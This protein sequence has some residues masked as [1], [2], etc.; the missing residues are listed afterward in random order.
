M[1]IKTKDVDLL[2]VYCCAGLSLVA[3]ENGM[4]MVKEKSVKMEISEQVNM[5]SKSIVLK[6]SSIINS[7]K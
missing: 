5:L 7:L 3:N 4:Q 6:V 1:F 2:L